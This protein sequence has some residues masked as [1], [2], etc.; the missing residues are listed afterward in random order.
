TSEPMAVTLRRGAVVVVSL[1]SVLSIA[2]GAAPSSS[3][4]PSTGVTIAAP[5]PGAGTSFGYY[6]RDGYAILT[7]QQYGSGVQEGFNTWRW[8]GKTWV[9]M[10]HGAGSPYAYSNMVY[11]PVLKMT[12]MI[13]GVLAPTRGIFPLGW[14]GS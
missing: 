11:D 2:C 13:G 1:V 10:V 9:Q 4:L 14:N 5:D 3:P 12:V 8:D 6:A 7:N